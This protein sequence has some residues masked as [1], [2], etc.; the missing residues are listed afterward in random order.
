MKPAVAWLP[1]DTLRGHRAA[2]P[3]AAAVASW[4]EKWISQPGWGAAAAFETGVPDDWSI[5]REETGFRLLGKS[6]ALIEL[7][8]AMLG[9]KPRPGATDLDLRFL[10]R[11][12]GRAIDD[13]CLS[14]ATVGS[15]AA[16]QGDPGAQAIW[17]LPIG[18]RQQSWFAVAVSGA[19]LAETARSRYPAARSRPKMISPREAL[20]DVRV[21]LSARIGTARLAVEQIG[22]LEVGDLLLLDEAATAPLRLTVAGEPSELYFSIGHDGDRLTLKMQEE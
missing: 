5:L 6:R 4:A 3:F 9:Q 18:T 21:P 15:S 8:C 2:Q 7:A 22:T 16:S 1:T 20:G 12:G 17:R 14:L 10:R 13:L 11:L 19:A